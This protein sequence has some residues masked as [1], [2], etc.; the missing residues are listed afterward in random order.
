MTES[1]KNTGIGSF[2]L[3][4][5]LFASERKP[6]IEFCFFS[7]ISASGIDDLFMFSLKGE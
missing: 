5:K 7:V 2:N 4:L 3:Q 1:Y 6:Y